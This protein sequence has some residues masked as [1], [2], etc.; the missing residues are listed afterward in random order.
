[1]NREVATAERAKY[2]ELTREKIE[3]TETTSGGI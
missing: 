2:F 1:M 3:L